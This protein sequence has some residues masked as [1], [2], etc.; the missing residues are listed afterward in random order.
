MTT[1]STLKEKLLSIFKTKYNTKSEINEKENNIIQSLDNKLNI[2][3]SFSGDYNDLENKPN[4][5][6]VDIIFNNEEVNN[7]G[8]FIRVPVLQCTVIG[9]EITIGNTTSQ[10]F[11]NTRGDVTIDWGDGTV[12]V[13]NNL[14]TQLTH[15]YVDNK[16][17]HEITF[18]GKVIGLNYTFK[19][20]SNLT[21]VYIPDSVTT[22]YGSCF[23]G[24]Q[25]LTSIIIPNSVTSIG[26]LCFQYCTNL[27]NIT[28]PSS[29]DTLPLQCFFS[30]T[31]LTSITIPS[32]IKQIGN[33]CFG[34]CS[35]LVDYQLYWKN[36]NII[37]YNNN[38]MP[39][40][41]NTTFTIPKGQTQNYINKG[42]PANKLFERDD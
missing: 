39:N 3:D 37:T 30:C 18:I 36:S 19:N 31:K 32:S 28:I 20:C 11:I 21:S 15:T 22:I 29:I 27:T 4:I 35:A 38:I 26:Q 10:T 16:D 2:D 7:D 17:V 42:Y 12:N 41:I 24:C 9:N 40:N 34:E 8:V 23:Q 25:N 14:K 6:P 13:I 33:L 5:L 1:L